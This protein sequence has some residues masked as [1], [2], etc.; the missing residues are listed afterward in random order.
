MK[1]EKKT[2]KKSYQ[3]PKIETEPLMSFGA[4]CNGTVNGGRKV[5]TGAPDFCNS[6]RLNS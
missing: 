1:N 3:K 4:V 5:S 6:K 2:T